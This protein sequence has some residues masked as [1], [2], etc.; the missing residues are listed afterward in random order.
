MTENLSSSALA[1]SLKSDEN[2]L[3]GVYFASLG[4]EKNRVDS[5]VMLGLLGGDGRFKVVQEPE[6]AQ[7]IIV[8]TCSF[9][10]AARE[11][12]IDTILELASFKESSRG[13]CKVL[14]VSGCLTQHYKHDLAVELPEVDLFIGTGQYHRIV[15]LLDDLDAGKLTGKVFIDT[16]TFIHSEND[17]RMHTG[18]IHSAYL[19]IAEGCDRRCG[20]CI[21]PH[22]RGNQRSRSIESLIQEAQSYAD[23]G[24]KELNVI[25]QDTIRYG[26]DLRDGQTNLTNLLKELVN[27]EGLEWIRLFYLYPEELSDELIEVIRKESKICKYIDMPIQHLD[28]KV[29]SLMNRRT[30]QA[31]IEERIAKLRREIPEVVIR[32]SVIVGYPGESEE[33]FQRMLS[34]LD[35]LDFDHLGVFK[36]SEE[37]DTFASKLIQSGQHEAVDKKSIQKRYREVYELQRARREKAV[38]S[39]LGKTIKVLVEGL[40]EETDL[41]LQGRHEGQAPQVDGCVLI[42]DGFANAGDFVEV[43]V[44]ETTDFDL[45]GG[46]QRPC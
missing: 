46:I 28:D 37:E 14:V 40:S 21:I 4:C 20:F 13:S 33:S 29:L 12:S 39:S 1:G 43:Q 30:N 22:L 15:E 27:V 31:Q 6:N 7:V 8:N 35:V 44:T 3:A 18:K 24:V 5:E 2:T 10:Q 17:P 9:V 42:N 41:L 25:S 16:P 36:F 38:K 23:R 45:V 11:E 34:G 19:K 32:S 26:R